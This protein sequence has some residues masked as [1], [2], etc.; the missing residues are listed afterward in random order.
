[1][2]IRECKP[3]LIVTY[4]ATEKIFCFLL[5]VTKDDF[6]VIFHDNFILSNDNVIIEIA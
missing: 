4:A 2:D 6:P 3:R 5:Q 1:M